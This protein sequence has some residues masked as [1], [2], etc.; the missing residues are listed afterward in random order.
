MEG[1]ERAKRFMKGYGYLELEDE[2]NVERF[3]MNILPEESRID[4][5]TITTNNKDKTIL[6]TIKEH[7]NEIV[8]LSFKSIDKSEDFV[9]FTDE[10]KLNFIKLNIIPFTFALF[11]INDMG[12]SKI[13]TDRETIKKAEH[14]SKLREKY[15]SER[16]VKEE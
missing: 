5:I 7:Y 4:L 9:G 2:G 3:K 1:L 11:E 16:T 8:E 12:A 14:L 15:A 13:K 6:E 10:E